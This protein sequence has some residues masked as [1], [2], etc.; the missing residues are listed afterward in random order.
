MLACLC[1]VYLQWEWGV[2]LDTSFLMQTIEWLHF[3]ELSERLLQPRKTTV[4]LREVNSMYR[5]GIT[6][7]FPRTRFSLLSSLMFSL[8]FY[9]YITTESWETVSAHS[10]LITQTSCKAHKCVGLLHFSYFITYLPEFWVNLESREQRY[11]S[12]WAVSPTF[13][14]DRTAAFIFDLSL[15]LVSMSSSLGL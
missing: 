13:T 7:V 1:E 9:N 4:I 14:P 10:R 8:L 5:T 6:S 3:S 15:C 12:S 11:L 2:D